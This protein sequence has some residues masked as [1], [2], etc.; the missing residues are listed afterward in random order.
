MS[1]PS[2]FP[3]IF[4]LGKAEVIDILNGDIEVTEKVDGSQI[5]FGRVGGELI[6]RSKGAQIFLDAP[7][8]MF[9]EAATVIGGMS[10]EEGWFYYGEYLKS[11]KHN[12]LRYGRV[13]KNHIALFGAVAPDGRFVSDHGSLCDIARRLDVDA[14]PLIYSGPGR[15]VTMETLKTWLGTESMLGGSLV[16]GVVLKNYATGMWL[17]GQYIPIMSA[18]FVSEAFKETHRKDWK[19][20]NTGK[21]QLLT[22]LDEYRSPARWQK[23]VQRL[24]EMGECD[25]SPRDIGRLIKLIQDDIEAEEKEEIKGKLWA[26]FRGDVMRSALQGFPDWYKE[27]IAAKTFTAQ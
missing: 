17:G 2:A 20:E 10:V 16:E 24:R 4:A 15:D 27:Q 14:V 7:E 19:K 21:G 12:V 18:K 13:P 23:S 25:D 8:K 22:M 26:I 9:A 6:A 1:V 11:P 3:K 5:G